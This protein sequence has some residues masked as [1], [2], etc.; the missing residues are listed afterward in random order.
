MQHDDALAL[1]V[2]R[3]GSHGAHEGRARHRAASSAQWHGYT[4]TLPEPI[5]PRVAQF[6]TAG[7][8]GFLSHSG[9]T[10]SRQRE[11]GPQAR[12]RDG[13][14]ENWKKLSS[15]TAEWF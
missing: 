15:K 4:P 8:A 5:S 2:I 3:H 1:L 9:N 13:P 7:R 6:G 10:G 11:I 14:G 12:Q